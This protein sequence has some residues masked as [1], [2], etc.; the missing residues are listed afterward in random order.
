[1]A[2]YR[3]IIAP[4]LII[5][6][7]QRA[8]A[9]AAFVRAGGHLI[10]TARSGMK[11][12]TNALLPSRQPGSVLASIADVE[13]ADYYVL[14]APVPIEGNSLKGQCQLWA[15]RLNVLDESV[16]VLA[17]YGKS[18]GWLDDQPAITVSSQ[19]GGLV[20]YAGA[21]LDELTQAAFIDQVL[22]SLQIEPAFDTPAG[23]EIC[24][25]TSA[26]GRAVFILINHE[27]EPKTVSLPWAAHEHLAGERVDGRL[28]LEAYG[29]AVLTEA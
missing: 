6:D 26:D 10:L 4:A 20:Y 23:V 28:E 13:V 12:R 22:K 25:R 27:R 11:D 3:L 5:I 15:E 21:Y 29:I 24:P 1:L 16:S 8:A 18:T 9:L 7:E 2:G 17:R 14:D 19:H